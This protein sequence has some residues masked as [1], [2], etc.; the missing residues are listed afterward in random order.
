MNYHLSISQHHFWSNPP[1][2][3]VLYRLLCAKSQHPIH[4]A[5]YC[6]SCWVKGELVRFFQIFCHIKKISPYQNKIIIWQKNV[7]IDAFS[8]IIRAQLNVC[9]FRKLQAML[10]RILHNIPEVGIFP[11]CGGCTF[12]DFHIGKSVLIWLNYGSSARSALVR[13]HPCPSYVHVLVRWQ[14]SPCT[15]TTARGVPPYSYNLR[16]LPH[17]YLSQKLALPLQARL[18]GIERTQ[19]SGFPKLSWHHLLKE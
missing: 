6:G 5:E 13:N 15:I 3:W 1:R 16:F 7:K 11:V 4:W 12:H 9:Q 14:K 18:G 10:G 17:H 8:W 2:T 19:T